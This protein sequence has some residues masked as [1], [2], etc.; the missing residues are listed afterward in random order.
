[1][2][3]ILGLDLGI[4]SIGW[5]LRDTEARGNQIT[6]SGVV[7]FSP[8]IGEA[9]GVEFSLAAERTSARNLR[10]Q[11]DRRRRR[12]AKLLNI[13]QRNGMAP[14]SPEEILDW[15]NNKKVILSKDYLDW[16][17]LDPYKA[18]SEAAEAKLSKTTIGRAL[19][20]LCQRR[21]FL[22]NRKTQTEDE[23]GKVKQSIKNLESEKGDL[24][25]GQYFYSINPHNKRIRERY[26]SR[27]EYHREFEIIADKQGMSEAL[28]TEIFEA[29]YD[30]RPLK[31]QKGKVASCRFEK[32]KKRSLKSQPEIEKYT[33]LSF[34]AN[35]KVFDEEDEQ[36][37]LIDED[38]K[39][40]LPIFSD[41]KGNFKFKKIA[42]KL[43]EKYGKE[44][45]FNYREDTVIASSK[46]TNAL[47]EFLGDDWPTYNNNGITYSDVWHAWLD[48]DNT[49]MLIDWA[50]TKLG[51][52]QKEAEKFAKVSVDNNTSSL[53]IK[54]A[55]NINVFLEHGFSLSESIFLAKVLSI[56]GI[57]QWNT[58]KEQWLT[59]FHDIFEDIKWQ[60]GVISTSNAAILRYRKNYD[61]NGT[62][63]EEYKELQED[64]EKAI[65][66]LRIN[67]EQQE[68]FAQ[69]VMDLFHAQCVKRGFEA[70]LANPR[71]K[72]KLEEY[73]V[74]ELGIDKAKAKLY[75]PSMT[76]IYDMQEKELGS[77]IKS[78]LKNPAVMR[79]MHLLR[80]LVNQLIAN[81]DI[82]K[83]TKVVFE[84][85]SEVNTKNKRA[86]IERWQRE[87]QRENEKYR[88]EISSYIGSDIVSSDLV[89]KY[90]LWVEQNETCIYSGANIG[91]AGFL[92]SNPKYEIEH[93]IPR[94]KSFDNSLVNLTLADQ[95][96]NSNKGNTLPAQLDNNWYK[97]ILSRVD[98][99]YK[100]KLI[101]AEKRYYAAKNKSKQAF[102][103]QEAKANAIQEKHYREIVWHYWKNKVSRFYWKEASGDFKPSMLTDTQ[104]MN[105]YTTAYLNSY[106]RQPVVGYKSGVIDEI[107]K[108][109][110]IKERGEKKDRSLHFHH[111][112]D[113]AVVAASYHR[114]PDGKTTYDALKHYQAESELGRKPKMPKPWGTLTQDINEELQKE[115]IV[116][117]H[118]K[119]NVFK[120]TK[121]K[122]RRRGE[123]CYKNDKASQE[124]GLYLSGKGVRASL[125]KE[126]YYG[127]IKNGDKPLYTTSVEVKKLTAGQ[128]N[129][130]IDKGIQ[131]LVNE[132]GLDH[133]KEHGLMRP[134]KHI[135]CADGNRKLIA[136]FKDRN[137]FEHLVSDKN[138][139]KK[140]ILD[141]LDSDKLHSFNNIKIEQPVKKIKI[142]AS[143]VK[144]PQIVRSVKY[145]SDNEF[146]NEV[147]AKN[148]G[149]Y[150]I[151]IY[152]GITH[153]GKVVRSYQVLSNIEAIR[154]FRL[155]GKDQLHPP[156]LTLK[157]RGK[158][159]K[160]ELFQT[161]KIG[162]SV[163]LMEPNEDEI[164]W[165][166]KTELQKRFYIIRG[167]AVSGGKALISC[168]HASIANYTQYT[169]KKGA[170]SL[171]NYVPSKILLATN[172]NGLIN[173]VNFTTNIDGSIEKI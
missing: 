129:K 109:W 60:K 108:E 43:R 14:I 121:L 85:T 2:S 5:A 168:S 157:Y 33:A 6:K 37:I 1:M 40:L 46:T 131:K 95:K 56:I 26:T 55:R 146:R 134:V 63:P 30:Q 126:T 87:R 89:K 99:I 52:E 165:T 53:S 92:S 96:E 120:N 58:D 110:G 102:S 11:Y 127:A 86:A 41:T 93:T 81:G 173:G 150:A 77:P 170:F 137:E 118:Y 136:S 83:E 91:R 66:R 73:I 103:T 117:Y 164:D 106:F 78:A 112:K 31:S 13:L 145:P 159:I 32:N 123:I 172:F 39:M 35:I 44:I 149:N 140:T 101:Q 54:A 84:A 49:E 171:T 104:V 132:I 125:H 47:Q 23:D 163:L 107:A 29:I 42:K 67:E 116:Y 7:V 80:K 38:R 36:I 28:R 90:R 79:M 148:D 10:K 15:R 105:R 68:D 119:D 113:A 141:K 97:E 34:I 71:I 122:Q 153:S 76:D 21:G 169:W 98:Q 65:S 133:I 3:I 8:G 158:D 161:L 151:N 160:F 62:S 64:I 88:N 82:D 154:T 124:N 72:D 147:Y 128:V 48:F 142:E 19:Y 69:E 9:K 138:H 17:A 18:R 12:K 143:D 57:D 50:K 130:I 74:K 166:D 61:K 24:T 45:T 139:W 155:Q 167:I 51:L 75:H 100:P 152:R 4:R 135:K 59:R 22:S 114:F 25:Y 144:S 156:S 16:I 27:K 94:S 70:I 115:C 111:M 20:H 162:M